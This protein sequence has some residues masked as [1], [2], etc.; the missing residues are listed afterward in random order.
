MM[1]INDRSRCFKKNLC[2][3]LNLNKSGINSQEDV[4]SKELTRRYLLRASS[5]RSLEKMLERLF[6][7]K[8]FTST[9]QNKGTETM[10]QGP[11]EPGLALGDPLLCCY[12]P[13]RLFPSPTIFKQWGMAVLHE[14]VE[15]R[16]ATC[17]RLPNGHSLAMCQAFLWH[18][19]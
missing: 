12:Q 11:C 3:K 19:R 15:V 10:Q 8:Y 4:H 14:C 5:L 9:T 17:R 13:R 16:S 18:T 2:I 7:E 1:R 6:L